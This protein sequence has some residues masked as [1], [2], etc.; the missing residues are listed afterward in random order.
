MKFPDVLYDTYNIALKNCNV[1]TQSYKVYFGP[2]E[3]DTPY[4]RI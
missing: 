2:I 3:W 1:T 4:N